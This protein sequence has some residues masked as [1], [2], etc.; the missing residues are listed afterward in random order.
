MV[1]ATAG[2]DVDI[3]PAPT[4]FAVDP[5]ERAGYGVMEDGALVES[6]WLDGSSL[7]E[8]ATLLDRFSRRTD[9]MIFVV[10]RQFQ[11]RGARF[12]PQSVETLMWRRH[13]WEVLM[14]IAGARRVRLWPSVWQS[15]MLSVVAGRMADGTVLKTKQRAMDACRYFWP[16]MTFKND[17]AA[18]AA[19]MCQ[20]YRNQQQQRGI[21]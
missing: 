2:H 15:E 20:W 4:I 5:G 18:D 21:L 9:E 17:N 13:M 14:D 1:D 10:E 6:D 12:N 8:I 7:L 3:W 16:G 11:A 19:L